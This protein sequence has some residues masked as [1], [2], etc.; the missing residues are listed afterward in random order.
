MSVSKG[1]Y[2]Q[3]VARYSENHNFGYRNFGL[4]MIQITFQRW[5]MSKRRVQVNT[6]E[7]D[8]QAGKGSATPLYRHKQ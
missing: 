5:A 7:K 1:T 8:L 6:G 3:L 2:T 4:N